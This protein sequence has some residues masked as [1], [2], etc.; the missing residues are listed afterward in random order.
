MK[1]LLRAVLALMLMAGVA[2]G[3][4]WL[5]LR[6]PLA[7]AAPSVELSIEPGTNPAE[8]ARAW[9]AAG[10]QTD[11]RWLYQWFK[12]SGQAKLIRAGSYE[13]H[14]GVTPRELLDKMVRGDQVL[15]QLRLIEGWN[16]RQVRAALAAA[17]HLKL[18]TASLSD[19]EVMAA[20]GQPGI[21]PEGRFFPD[22][23]AYSRGVSDLTVLKRA[24]AAMQRRLAAAWGQRAADLPLK[25]ADEALILASIVEKET[26]APGD[27]SKVAAVFVNRLRLGMP[28]Q[29]DP[30]V[31]YGL[32][33][34]YGG[35]LRKRDLTTD[36]P[37][38][39][40][41]R[42]GLP[43]TP[44]AMP[45]AA[46]LQAALQPAAVKSLYFVARGDGSSEFSDDLAAHNRAVNK[47]IRGK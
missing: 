18:T 42:T 17:P 36:T 9:V 14:A 30:T 13:V 8:V 39:T 25:N 1:W 15:E 7:L 5:W 11:A 10:V 4:A 3:A 45:G 26:G 19:A 2:T 24:H 6:S 38:N 20:L 16:W 43:P 32:G 47:Y 21:A 23:Y 40:Y 33:E 46:S 44:I 22:T 35:N 41:T 27:R 34:A 37:F 12:L 29:T 28:L 31:I